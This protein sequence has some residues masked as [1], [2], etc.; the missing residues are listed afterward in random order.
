MT[1]KQ[2]QEEFLILLLPLK[3]RLSRYCTAL[4]RNREDAKDLVS[5]TILIAFR[6]FEKVRYKEAFLSYLFTIASRQHKYYWKKVK[7]YVKEFVEISENDIIDNSSPDTKLDIEILYKAINKL[8]VK[9]KETLVLFELS[10]LKLEEIKKIQG[11]TLSGVKSRLRRARKQLAELLEDNPINK[12]S[13]NE[14]NYNQTKAPVND[15]Y[16]LRFS[17]TTELNV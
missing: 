12:L 10:E 9:L 5:E 16:L 3:D 13:E 14:T 15:E 2:K 8:P 6:S 17:K 4:T 1:E 11:G 7:R